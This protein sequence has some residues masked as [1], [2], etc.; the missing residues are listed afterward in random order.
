[1]NAFTSSFPKNMMAR[2]VLN[3]LKSRDTIA[4]LQRSI[5]FD[6]FPLRHSQMFW[7]YKNSKCLMWQIQTVFFWWLVL[8]C[9]AFY[10][11][12]AYNRFAYIT[13]YTQSKR[14][15]LTIIHCSLYPVSS[16]VLGR[17]EPRWTLVLRSLQL[18]HAFYTSMY[19]EVIAV[20]HYNTGCFTIVE[21]KRR[22]LKP[23]SM[24]LFIFLFP[25]C[26]REIVNLSIY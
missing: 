22:L 26:H 7:M 2:P 11:N 15:L 13:F 3:L 1:M 18:P 23:L 12:L 8:A 14:L 17:S 19:L 6:A 20:L 10:F 4:V 24:T 9:N 25:D 16:F 21:T 5:A